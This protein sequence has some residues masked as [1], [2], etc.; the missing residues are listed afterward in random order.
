MR[1]DNHANL[2]LSWRWEPFHLVG[3]PRDPKQEVARNTTGIG[4]AE[5]NSGLRS[6]VVSS[7]I[8][9]SV[10]LEVLVNLEV[11]PST[12]MACPQSP[13][14]D[15]QCMNATTLPLD[16]M[17]GI[18]Q[19][20]PLEAYV[21][22]P[23]VQLGGSD[24]KPCVIS[25]ITPLVSPVAHMNTPLV[26][27]ERNYPVYCVNSSIPPMAL[28][29][30]G[31]KVLNLTQLNVVGTVQAEV[32]HSLVG[33]WVFRKMSLDCPMSGLQEE[34]ASH[35]FA[36]ALQQQDESDVQLEVSHCTPV[37]EQ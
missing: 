24:H 37:G 26:Q 7:L 31:T 20:V 32:D 35:D 17:L 23:W 34:E 28:L 16:G 15:E 2:Q 5:V 8:H 13:F 36:L 30:E 1:G 9:A 19:L 10:V 22:T 29:D 6:K 33:K 18:T 4:G 25:S 11:Y 21:I 14:E 12:H 3:Q 27:L